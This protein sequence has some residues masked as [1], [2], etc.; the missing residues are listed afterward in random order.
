MITALSRHVWL[1]LTFRHDGRGLPSSWPF[2]L[3]VAGLSYL[4]AYIRWSGNPGDVGPSDAMFLLT[5]LYI[6]LL[7]FYKPVRAAFG[8]ALISIVWDCF[9]MGLSNVV[10]TDLANSLGHFEAL[11]LSVFLIRLKDYNG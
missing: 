11:F 10:G 9:V 2:F 3:F 6:I 5:V 1:L 7:S 4:V 8:Y